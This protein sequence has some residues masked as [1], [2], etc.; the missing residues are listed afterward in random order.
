[1]SLKLRPLGVPASEPLQP[2][3]FERGRLIN[4]DDFES[5]SLKYYPAVTGAGTV[6][7]STTNPMFGDFSL[8]MVTGAVINNYC[9]IHYATSDFITS[10][11]RAQIGFATQ[12]TIA[13]NAVVYINMYYY[14]GS[15]YY[16]AALQYE[17]VN[18]QLSYYGDD[19][20]THLID[21]IK[22]HTGIAAP[23]IMPYNT[24]GL[25]IDLANETYSKALFLGREFD[26]ASHNL[27]EVSLSSEYRGLL[28][29]IMLMTKTTAAQTAYFDRFR[30]M[31][32][33]P[34]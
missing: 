21:T 8:K 6:A 12:P 23:E 31:E 13:S 27:Y 5:A 16:Q 29:Y 3:P 28:T 10:R 17:T 4:W 32:D 14:T 1:M 7:R 33:E 24:M 15:I 30:L 34:A 25:E 20:A 2:S 22:Y 11:I 26:L 19:G 18:S 9:K